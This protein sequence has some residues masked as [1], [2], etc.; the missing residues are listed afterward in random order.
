MGNFAKQFTR[1]NKFPSLRNIKK[2]QKQFTLEGLWKGYVGYVEFL[3]VRRSTSP[4]AT[5]FHTLGESMLESAVSASQDRRQLIKKGLEILTEI[6]EASQRV[7]QHQRT[8]I[9]EQ[10][11]EGANITEVRHILEF[12]H[13]APQH[14]R[15]PDRSFHPT[16]ACSAH[17]P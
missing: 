7:K 8:S 4:D 13:L 2:Q 6:T 11:L 9:T 17:T 15:Q 5:P 3:C 1:L 10:Q 16:V 12:A 14:F